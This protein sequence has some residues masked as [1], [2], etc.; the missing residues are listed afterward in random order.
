VAE[1]FRVA[2]GDAGAL[3]RAQRDRKSI[4]QASSEGNPAAATA[5]HPRLSLVR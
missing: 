5:A 3:K 2:M 1:A 4:D